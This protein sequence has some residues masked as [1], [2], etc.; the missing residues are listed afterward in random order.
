MRSFA[1]RLFGPEVGRLLD[2]IFEETPEE[3]RAADRVGDAGEW[4]GTTP[5]DVPRAGH[6]RHWHA[7]RGPVIGDQRWP[8]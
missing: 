5:G 6:G 8:R 1:Q 3:R 2:M 7:H 4:C